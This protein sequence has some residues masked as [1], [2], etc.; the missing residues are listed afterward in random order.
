[1]E[2]WTNK[3]ETKTVLLF[4]ETLELLSLLRSAQGEV[5]KKVVCGNFSERF[6]FL[7]QVWGKWN[8]DWIVQT[9]KLFSFLWKFNF[10]LFFAFADRAVYIGAWDGCYAQNT[11]SWTLQSSQQPRPSPQLSSSHRSNQ[12]ASGTTEWGRRLVGVSRSGY[13][14]LSWSQTQNG[15]VGRK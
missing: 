3:M 14:N 6:L 12:I 13:R 2:H 7:I 9:T 11:N 10:V 5:G 1:M 8:I 4:S 15:I